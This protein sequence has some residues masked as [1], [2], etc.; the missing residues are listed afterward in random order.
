MIDLTLDETPPKTV[1][2]KGGL[3]LFLDDP[4]RVQSDSKINTMYKHRPEEQNPSVTPLE[5]RP[6]PANPF[7]KPLVAPAMKR[8]DNQKC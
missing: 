5:V 6:R 2:G 8:I 7:E 1:Q 3:A 4:A